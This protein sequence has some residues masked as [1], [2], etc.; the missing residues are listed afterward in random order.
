MFDDY[1]HHSFAV[2]IKL[3]KQTVKESLIWVTVS[4]QHEIKSNSHE[5]KVRSVSG[6]SQTWLISIL[7]KR[8]AGFFFSN[9]QPSTMQTLINQVFYCRKF[10][11][12][13][14]K[15]L[16]RLPNRGILCYRGNRVN[17]GYL[18]SFIKMRQT[19]ILFRDSCKASTARCCSEFQQI[20]TFGLGCQGYETDA[21]R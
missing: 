12:K 2:K 21:G 8:Q 11:W 16:V 5:V 4:S 1:W 13:Q 3:I 18:I 17:T 6:P 15:S 19:R 14:K 10:T 9:E 7:K 20:K